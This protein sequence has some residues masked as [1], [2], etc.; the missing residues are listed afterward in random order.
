MMSRHNT[1]WHTNGIMFFCIF[2]MIMSLYSAFNLHSFFVA[3]FFKNN[4]IDSLAGNTWKLNDMLSSGIGWAIY[5][6][7]V[8]K[9]LLAMGLLRTTMNVRKIIYMLS[10]FI[11]YTVENIT[12]TGGNCGAD[13]GSVYMCA[14]EFI[15]NP[16]ASMLTTAFFLVI[17]FKQYKITHEELKDKDELEK[18]I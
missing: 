15:V 1:E 4:L 13:D 7:F 14:A 17:F 5:A 10:L 2:T 11:L 12:T 3:D 16:Y 8:S 18:T 9:I 6:F